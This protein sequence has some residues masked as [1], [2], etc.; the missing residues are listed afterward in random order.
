MRDKLENCFSGSKEMPPRLIKKKPNLE[1]AEEHLHKAESNLL[2]MET[3]LKINSLI[4]P[5]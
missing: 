3:R 5:S 4:G 1:I 2:A